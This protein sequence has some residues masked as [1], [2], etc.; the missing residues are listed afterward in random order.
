MDASMRDRRG[1]VQVGHEPA[2]P[3]KVLHTGIARALETAL[4]TLFMWF[5]TAQSVQAAELRRVKI[6]VPNIEIFSYQG[7]VA[8]GDA[9]R[10]QTE[11]AKVAPNKRVAILLN[12]PGG[13]SSEGKAL[14]R[15]FYNARIS[16]FVLGNGGSCASACAMAF[17]GGRDS[18]TG[19]PLRV[20]IQGGSLG[21]HQFWYPGIRPEQKF[22]KAE[23]RKSVV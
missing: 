4:A 17:L 19:E 7:P 8:A 11:L 13:L 20:I 22:K 9:L 6:G 23:D 3:R 12:S 16:T 14:G 5:V 10:L 18:V 21:F 1:R 2:A 15:L